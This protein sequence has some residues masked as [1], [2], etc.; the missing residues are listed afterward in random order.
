RRS[1]E[2]A[3]GRI[4]I[5]GI[6][7]GLRREY[8]RALAR[9]A[10]EIRSCRL[11]S[12]G[13]PGGARLTSFFELKARLST[14]KLSHTP[15]RAH[16]NGSRDNLRGR[17]SPLHPRGHRRLPARRPLQHRRL[18]LSRPLEPSHRLQVLQS[19]SPD[20]D[21]CGGVTACQFAKAQTACPWPGTRRATSR[22]GQ[23]HTFMET[24][25]TRRRWLRTRPIGF[26]ERRSYSGSSPF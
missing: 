13:T 1:A 15:P 22:I 20:P 18:R 11:K 21:K 14:D 23:H 9:R 24:S 12:G 10:A 16:L 26:G 6:L 8:R 5:H 3:N 25:A 17:L 2:N 4:R 19:L 7:Q